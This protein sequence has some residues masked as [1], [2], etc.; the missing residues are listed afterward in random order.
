MMM[1]IHNIYDGEMAAFL[2]DAEANS[3]SGRVPNQ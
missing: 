3:S 1:M 2:A